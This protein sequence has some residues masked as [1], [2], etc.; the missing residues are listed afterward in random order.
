MVLVNTVDFDVWSDAYGKL[1]ATV[2]DKKHVDDT[3]APYGYD[4]HQ[5]RLAAVS[6]RDAMK[7]FR[8]IASQC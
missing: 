4:R 6:R 5:I 1:T 7:Q 8:E 2:S 3:D